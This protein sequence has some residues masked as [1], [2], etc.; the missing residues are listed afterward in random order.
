MEAIRDTHKSRSFSPPT[1]FKGFRSQLPW[2]LFFTSL[3]FLNFLSRVVLAPLLPVMEEDLGLSHGAAGGLFF[4]VSLGYFLG[5]LGSGFVSARF[6]HRGAVVASSMMIGVALLAASWSRDLWVLRVALCVMGAAA[7]IYLPSGLASITELV[8]PRDYGK[9]IAVHELAPN[10]GLMAAPFLTEFILHVTSWRGFLG[11]LGGVGIL[12][13][14]IFARFGRGGEFPGE[15]PRIR[16]IRVLLSEPSFWIMILFFGLGI[17]GSLGIYSMLP[18]FLVA[19]RGL[20]RQWANT[21]VGLSRIS[22]LFMAFVAG[23]LTDVVGPKRT[24]GLVL[25]ATGGMTILLSLAHA[26]WIALPVLLQPMM[27]VCFFPPAFAALAGIGPPEV[28]NLT[29]SLTIPG[30]FLLGAGAFP[31]G[32][33]L[34]GEV[35]SF[36]A[37]MFVAGMLILS[38]ALLAPVLRLRPQGGSESPG[39]T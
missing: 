21:L 3:F 39:S 4:I 28:R 26:H 17:G 38:G 22:G 2:L 32:I 9:A 6:L 24:L 30:A 14:M 5:L 11:I 37:G 33:G 13:G 8:R 7:G 35:V 10:L 27:A 36:S 31:A 34:L 23:W 16:S 20:D 19:E 18:L 12:A 15:A 29:V 25:G 1:S